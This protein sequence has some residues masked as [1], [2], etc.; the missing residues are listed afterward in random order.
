MWG[1]GTNTFSLERYKVKQEM[2]L[3]DAISTLLFYSKRFNMPRLALHLTRLCIML[4][5]DIESLV[6]NIEGIVGFPYK[7]Y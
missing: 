6:N 1:D 5:Y 3:Y 2:N 4:T 7:Q